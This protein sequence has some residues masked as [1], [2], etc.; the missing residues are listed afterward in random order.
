MRGYP[1]FNFPAFMAAAKQLRDLGHEVFNPAEKD[2]EKYGVE[3]AD[4]STGDLKDAEKAG[5]NLREAMAQDLGYI[6]LEADSIALLPG[7][8][9]SKGATAEHAAALALGLKVIVQHDFGWTEV[10][11]RTR[12][13]KDPVATAA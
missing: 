11:H 9:K 2:I 12:K 7:W 13:P 5:F 8:E 3:V 4:S 10:K 6:C 1:N